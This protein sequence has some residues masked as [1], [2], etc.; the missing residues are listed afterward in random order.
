MKKRSEIKEKFKWDLSPLADENEDFKEILQKIRKF[1]PK[2][3]KFE[4]KLNNKDT[5][6]EYLTLNE[7]FTKFVEPIV[8]YNYLKR[9]EK[10]SNDAQNEKIEMLNGVLN[11][12]SV[13][14]SFASS[15]LYDLSDEMLDDIIKDERFADFDRSFEIIKKDKKHKLSKEEEKLLAGMDFLGGFS[16]NMRNISDLDLDYGEVEDSKGKKYPLNQSVYGKYMRSADRTLRKNTFASLNGAYGKFINTLS[17][18]YINE[19]KSN[20]YFAKIRKYKSALVSA[21]EGEEVSEKVYKTLIKMVEENLP[22]LFDYFKIKQKELSLKD[23]YIYDAMTST[24][25]GDEKVYTYEEAVEIVKKAVAPLGEEYV[26]LIQKAKDERWIDVYANEGK[27]SGAYESAIYGY[28]PYVLTNFEGD[29]DS[30]FTLAHELGHAMHSYYSDKNQ[31]RD[32]ASYTIFLAEIASTTNEILLI[33]YLLSVSKTEEQK[34]VLFNKL[35]DEVKGTIFRQTMFAE[36]E[37]KMHELHERGEG[38]T[39]DKLCN[40]YY[41]LN[42]KYFGHVKLTEETKYEWARIPHFFNAFYVYKYAT[43]MICAINFANRILKGEKG[44]REDYFKFLSAGRSNTPIKILKQSKCD[45]EK[46]ETFNN[47][48][49]YLKNILKEWKKLIK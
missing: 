19:I 8:E 33:N 17:S 36:F 31:P 14:T 11:E 24:E 47:C 32:K 6:L 1:L 34:K 18:N 40:E 7:E 37:E 4:G 44:A 15:E 45:L 25:K 5:I 20:C 39:K 28:H 38:L 30:V 41:N 3:K 35:F 46:E 48:F 16:T 49:D 21:L 9:D 27:R 2:F 43:G 22:V 10:L 12:F 13:Q 23:F 26:S 29:L 42:K